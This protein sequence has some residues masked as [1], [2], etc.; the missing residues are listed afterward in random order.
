MLEYGCNG[1]MTKHKKAEDDAGRLKV[2]YEK[3]VEYLPD[4]GDNG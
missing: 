4:H 2:W 1:P 3:K